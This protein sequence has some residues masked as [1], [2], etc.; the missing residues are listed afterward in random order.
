M[1]S[2]FNQS[3][4]TSFGITNESSFKDKHSM[5]TM[6]PFY[7]EIRIICKI[8]LFFDELDQ[9]PEKDSC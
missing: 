1:V 3:S 5:S 9:H 7:R 4:P 6:M 2:D 8:I